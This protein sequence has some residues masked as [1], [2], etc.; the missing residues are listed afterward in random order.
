MNLSSYFDQIY[1]I[2]LDELHDR[3]ISIIDQIQRFNLTNITIIDAINKNILD[4]EK[5]TIELEFNNKWNKNDDALY[6]E[7]I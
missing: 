2:H 7:E 1:I 3:K 5:E 6:I 4:N